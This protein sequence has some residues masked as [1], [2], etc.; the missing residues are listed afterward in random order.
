MFSK[1][2]QVHL[3]KQ[4]PPSAVLRSPGERAIVAKARSCWRSADREICGATTTSRLRRRS[5]VPAL[6]CQATGTS[7]R[8]RWSHRELLVVAP[9]TARS[10]A[11]ATGAASVRRRAEGA[12]QHRLV[13]QWQLEVPSLIRMEDHIRLTLIPRCGVVWCVA[14]RLVGDA[15][16]GL[17]CGDSVGDAMS[18]RGGGDRRR[19]WRCRWRRPWRS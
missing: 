5:G 7:R 10:C 12:R 17:G 6:A 2:M 16:S 19:P 11:V 1:I 15:M 14:G 9:A 3:T 8:S 4:S 13:G 18:G